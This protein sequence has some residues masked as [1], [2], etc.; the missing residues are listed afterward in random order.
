MGC[1]Y[2]I[3]ILMNLI[4]L[5]AICCREALVKALTVHSVIGVILLMYVKMEPYFMGITDI[6]VRR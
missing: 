5:V 4:F 6:I 3:R 1:V 2:K